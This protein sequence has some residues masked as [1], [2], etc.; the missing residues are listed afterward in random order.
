V[1]RYHGLRPGSNLKEEDVMWSHG[2]FYWN[3]LMA[4]DVEKAK[5]FYAASVGWTF[6]AMPMAEGTYW[7]AKMGDKP[8]GGIFPMSG[9]NFI[10]VPEH[11]I[12]YLAVDDVDARLQKATAAGARVMREPFDVPAVGRIAILHEP[13]GA[14]IGWITPVNS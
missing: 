6:D 3:E 9:P 10:G 2:S 12:P 4:R 1:D 14:V 7:V 13:G 8:V 11:W 5:S